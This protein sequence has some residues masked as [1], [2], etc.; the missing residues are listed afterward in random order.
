[1]QTPD[2]TLNAASAWLLN[3][4]ETLRG[5]QAH[6]TPDQR[7]DHEALG[8]FLLLFLLE[9]PLTLIPSQND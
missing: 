8:Q 3:Q 4:L 6:W 1:M 7:S 9:V 2:E 5:P